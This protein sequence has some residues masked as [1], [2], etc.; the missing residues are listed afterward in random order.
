MATDPNTAGGPGTDPAAAAPELRLKLLATEAERDQLRQRLDWMEHSLSW[1]ITAP[2]RA[3]K[4]G[5]WATGLAAAAWRRAARQRRPGG[6]AGAPRVWFDITNLAEW[7]RPF[8]T[9]VQR[10][11]ASVVRE[12]AAGSALPS[13]AFVRFDRFRGFVTIPSDAAK[14]MAE[15]L[16]AGVAPGGTNPRPRPAGIRGGDA[17]VTLGLTWFQSGYMGEVQALRGRGVEWVPLVYDIIPVRLAGYES[18]D[19]TS[20]LRRLAAAASHVWTIS[21]FSRRDFIDYCG[22]TGARTPRASVVYL[23]D[24]PGRAPAAA[25]EIAG[26]PGDE[27]FVLL[28]S[29]FEQRKNQLLAIHAWEALLAERGPE[30]VPLLVLAGARSDA[31]ES[32]SAAATRPELHRKVRILPDAAEDAVES[33]RR[34]CLFTLYPSRYEGWGLPVRE[35]M[36][37]G[38]YCLASNATSVP[39]AGGALCGYHGPDDLP[40]YVAALRELIASPETLAARTNAVRN[41]F[42]PRTW[43]E[44]VDAMEQSLL[45]LPAF[46][47][48]R[49]GAAG[50]P[51]QRPPRT[52]PETRKVIVC[53]MYRSGSTWAYNVAYQVLHERGSVERLGVVDGNDHRW[54][55]G[56][57][58]ILAKWHEPDEQYALWLRDGTAL[59]LYSYRDLRDVAFS[60]AHKLGISFDELVAAGWLERFQAAD[61]FWRSLPNVLVQRYEDLAADPPAAAAEIADHLGVTLTRAARDRIAAETSR[62]AHGALV[63][64]LRG[65][66][67]ASG[68]DLSDPA[69]ALLS[70]PETQL[71]WNHI[72]H[73]ATGWEDL[74]TPEQRR[75]LEERCGD[76]LRANGYEAAAVR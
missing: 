37:A 75:V 67:E 53:G 16:H 66:L 49:R 51:A 11:V 65:R 42:R 62:E 3:V 10:T 58:A 48:P 61:A 29:A 24:D 14:D 68:V 43:R 36:A 22:S 60:M 1:R 19:Y 20:N 45:E 27:P 15:R 34:R 38:K 54:T 7:N 41:R 76:W 32:V 63:E 28:V 2:L 46:Q 23:G 30:G 50:T 70:D 5:Q 40:G 9:G 47:H 64:T 72:R 69:N 18:G 55:L 57:P 12:L 59:G 74:A 39:E 25:E 56:G 52:L 8:P 35:S 6:R 26:D 4:E 31:F 73:G 44:T 71:H 33:L 17:L 21:E 13:V